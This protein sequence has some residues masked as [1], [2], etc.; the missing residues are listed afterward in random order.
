M[1]A[2]SACPEESVMTI[3]FEIPPEIEHQI[4]TNGIDLGREARDAYLL[5]LYRQD[6]ISHAQLRDALKVSFHE[7]EKL[8][9][10]H[11]AGHDI[12]IVEFG[13]G[14]ELLRKARPQ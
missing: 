7:A 2:R 3:S 8:I 14:R 1:Q 6:R 10:E 5:E 11:G 13:V 12:P 4:R 9:K